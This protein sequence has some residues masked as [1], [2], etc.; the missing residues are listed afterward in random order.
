MKYI[1][2]LQNGLERCIRDKDALLVGEDIGVPYGGA[3]KVTKG[4]AAQYPDSFMMT[5]MSEQGFTGMGIGYALQGG[6]VVVEIMFSDFITLCADQLVN[7]AAKLYDLYGNDL[8]FVLRTPSG[9]YRG[10]GATHSQSLERMF[11]GISGLQVLAPS[12]FHPP[13]EVLCNALE[14]GIPTLFIENKL[15]YTRNLYQ[16][17]EGSFLH[18][19]EAGGI[20][21]IEVDGEQPDI[22]VIT[23]GGMAPLVAGLCEKLMLDEELAVQVLVISD[24]NVGADVLTQQVKSERILTVEEG[25]A[26][27]GIGAALLGRFG[28]GGKS[29]CALGARPHS[30]YSGKRLEDEILP[31]ESDVETAILDMVGR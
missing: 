18:V 23:Y 8:H 27:G 2:N 6:F 11:V 30:L 3:F 15:D 10:Y 4:L 1:E 17:E 22:S 21:S 19:Q 25:W 13:G 14:S 20:T 7:H 24:L 31:Q 12:I 9:G 16:A 26:D 5:P 28:A 29:G